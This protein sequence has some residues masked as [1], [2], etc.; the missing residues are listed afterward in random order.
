MQRNARRYCIA[1]LV[2]CV[3]LI[4]GCGG[5]SNVTTGNLNN[6]T[7]S[8]AP[9]DLTLASSIDDN[10]RHS[11]TVPEKDLSSPPI[12]GVS[13][14]STWELN[15]QHYVLLSLDDLTT[16]NN[17]GTVTVT[18]SLTI[19]PQDGVEHSH[20][21]SISRGTTYTSS[22]VEGHIHTIVLPNADLEAPPAAGVTYTSS[23]DLSHI[24][25]VTITYQQ[26]ITVRDGGQVIITSSTS[27]DPS[28]G[29]AHSHEWTL[30][31]I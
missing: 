18:S 26:L 5:N 30:V 11:L 27:T 7:V 25:T 16:I 8:T 31:R 28:T 20:N 9:R 21:W 14:Q 6:V 10:H 17:G 29:Y 13:Y 1:A 3:F 24:H 22:I 15:H 12:Q 23:S 19:N 4:Q 2:L